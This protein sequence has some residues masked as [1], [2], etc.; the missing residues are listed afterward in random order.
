[1]RYIYQP[2]THAI[3]VRVTMAFLGDVSVHNAQL[4]VAKYSKGSRKAAAWCDALRRHLVV[5]C[6]SVGRR[7]TPLLLKPEKV[8]VGGDYCMAILLSEHGLCV[9]QLQYWEGAVFQS[10]C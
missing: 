4:H 6:W 9:Y 8:T 2:T 3:R 7:G 5:L 10:K 1:M